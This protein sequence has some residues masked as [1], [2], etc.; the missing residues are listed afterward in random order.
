VSN[1]LNW[2]VP[3]AGN[4]SLL[5]E[6]CCWWL[7]SRQTPAMALSAIAHLRRTLPTVQ[8]VRV[9]RPGDPAPG[10]R[11]MIFSWIFGDDL[12][13]AA[14]TCDV[15]IANPSSAAE[16]IGRRFPLARVIP[17]ADVFDV[18]PSDF[19]PLA[20]WPHGFTSVLVQ[21]TSG[22]PHRCGYCVWDHPYRRR[23]AEIVAADICRLLA[24]YP[25]AAG[26][27]V[28]ILANEVTGCSDWL[29]AFCRA[30]GNGIQW[31]SDANVRNAT[32][33]DLELARAHGCAELTFGVEALDD[34]LLA[35]I[36]K[37]NTVDDALRVFRWCQDLGI[38]YRFALRQRIGET[39]DQLDATIA[40]LH[41][42]RSEGL[43]PNYITIGPM[44]RWPGNA[45]WPAAEPWGSTRYPRWVRPIG[46]DSVRI[47]DRW[48]LV[49]D[50]VSAL[51][52]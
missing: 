47:C 7:D 15:L 51:L 24:M 48:R 11:A 26:A 36:G 41:R 25:A 35:A 9:C 40:T 10:M 22:C 28:A 43:H 17:T 23:P 42:M 13:A 14:E 39:A 33:E 38:R 49:V 34:E 18:V 37:G 4:S 31:R 16:E 6:E 12:E 44:C 45:R 1:R 27:D 19:A 52:A 46:S 30:L 32:L 50:A 21:A 2:L 20:D 8:T 5:Q 3:G 29:A